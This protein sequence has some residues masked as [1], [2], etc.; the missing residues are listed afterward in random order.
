LLAVAGLAGCSGE[1]DPVADLRRVVEQPPP[2]GELELEPLPDPVKP[3]QVSFQDLERSPFAG[4]AGAGGGSGAEGGGSESAQGP[5]P[6]QDRPREPLEQYAI[7]S[8]ALV[9]T[10]EKPDGEWLAFV[11]APDGLV[12]TVRV[13]NYMGQRHGRVEAIRADAVELRELVPRGEG[14]WK[15]QHRTLS[16]QSQQSQVTGE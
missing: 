10:M 1:E 14:R 4:L 13:G 8:L 11:E 9:G 3:N 15:V 5:H 2:Q 12:H 7:G 6:D 16:L